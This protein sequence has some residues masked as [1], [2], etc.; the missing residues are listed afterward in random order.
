M[1]NNNFLLL[2]LTPLLIWGC[3]AG[4]APETGASG[5]HRSEVSEA[6]ARNL[7]IRKCSLCH[8]DDGKLGASK[9]PDLSVSSMS[10][11]ERIALITYGKGTMPGQNGILNKAEIQAVARYIDSFRE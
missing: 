5:S 3:G 4:D 9:S 2:F 8:G 10:L 1:V 7:Y 6:Q 11:E